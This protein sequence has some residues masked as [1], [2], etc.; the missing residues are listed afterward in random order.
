MFLEFL[1]VIFQIVWGSRSRFTE[2]T[3]VL[4][5]FTGNEIGISR[6]AEKM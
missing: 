6:F 2:N 5:Q 1:N 3:L 4:S